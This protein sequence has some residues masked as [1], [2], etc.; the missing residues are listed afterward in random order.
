[1]LVENGLLGWLSIIWV[2]ATALVVLY[3]A[4]REVRDPNLQALPW[5][6]FCSV[7]GFVVT[8]QGFSARSMMYATKSNARIPERT[9]ETS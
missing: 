3:R 2:L 6:V 8:L 9:P 1:M 5:A 4:Q 7:A